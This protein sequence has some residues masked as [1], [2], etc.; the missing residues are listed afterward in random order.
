MSD[1]SAGEL[2]EVCA[3]NMVWAVAGGVY[4]CLVSEGPVL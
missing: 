2:V 3:E 1:H 4:L